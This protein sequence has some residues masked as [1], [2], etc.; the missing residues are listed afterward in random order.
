MPV[1]LLDRK[2]ASVVGPSSNVPQ[3][4]QSGSMPQSIDRITIKG[5]KAIRALEDFPLSALNVLIGANGAGKSSFVSFFS[6]LQELVNGGLELAVNKGGGADAHLFLGP[7]VTKRIEAH[8]EFGCNGYVFQLERTVDNRLIFADERIEYWGTPGCTLDVNRSLGKGHSESKLEEQLKGGRNKAISEYIFD[9]VS[10]WTVYHFHDTSETAPMRGTCS[11]RDN[12]RL[13]PDAGN[14]A[15][16][17][18]RLKE[19]DSP[20]YELICDTVRLVAPF[21]K[22]FYFR[23]K[24]ANGDRNLQL[25]WRQRNTTYPFHAGQLSD[26]T[27]RFV[28]LATVLLQPTPPATILID[29]PELG[30][31]PFALNTLASLIRQASTKTQLIVSTQSAPLLNAFQPEEIVVV[32][33]KE[34]E[35]HFHRLSGDELQTWLDEEYTLGELWQKEIVGGGPVYE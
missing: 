4:R 5:F 13:R 3:P 22:Q 28:A 29:E 9:A 26:G 6:L 24:K 10:S 11:V 25:E 32:D 15:A 7:K 23:P 8:L 19:E 17:L 18:L 20:V 16:F 21:F 33:R 31:H 34:G 27:L 12:E 14:L 2:I 1:G 30:L 35:S